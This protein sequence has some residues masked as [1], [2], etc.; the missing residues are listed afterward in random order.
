MPIDERYMA[1]IYKKSRA[2]SATIRTGVANGMAMLAN[3]QD[4][5]RKCS[6]NKIANTANNT[7]YRLLSDNQNP[8]L[9][10]S[11]TDN[12]SLI[13][14]ASPV[15]FLSKLENIL[16]IKNN[17]PIAIVI[18]ESSGDSFFQ[19]DYMTGLRWALADLSWEIFFTS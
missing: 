3:N 7:V 9:W 14:Q 13:A 18:K 5:L 1:N 17:N 19:S 4:I 6:A 2:Y 10:M 8:K 15:Q 12:T 16:E 11:I